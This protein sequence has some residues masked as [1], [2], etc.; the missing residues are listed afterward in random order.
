MKLVTVSVAP[1]GPPAVT[2]MTMSASFSLK[3]MRM[4]I[5]GDDDR[6]HQREDDL[7]EALPRGWRRRRGRP[8]SPR[9][10]A[11]RPASSMIIMNGMKVQASR[12]MIVSFARSRGWRRRRDCPSRA[13]GRSGRP[14]RSGTRASTCRSS[15]SPRRATASAAAGTTT[16]KNLR[17]RISACEQQREAEGD[18]VFD[19]DRQHVPDHVAQRVPVERIVPHLHD[20]VEAVETPAGRRRE[21]FQSEKAIPRPKSSGKTTIATT[22]SDGGQHEQDALAALAA[23]HHLADAQGDGP[24]EVGVQGWPP[25]GEA[26]DVGARGVQRLKQKVRTRTALASQIRIR[27]ARTRPGE[28]SSE[29]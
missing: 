14:G 2:L 26:G 21:R 25:G 5:D 15:S 17:A 23:D 28:S 22:K 10:Q 18:G 1:P 7:P 24:E 20:V 4:T 13:R 9:G 8:R 6:Q 29:V 11:C 12:T 3:M 27:P 19:E 16:R